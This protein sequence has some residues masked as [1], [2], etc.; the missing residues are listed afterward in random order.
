MS[1][2]A[3][4][5]RIGRCAGKE[6]SPKLQVLWQLLFIIFGIGFFVLG[7]VSGGLGQ[8]ILGT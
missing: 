6:L 4:S 7:L 5:I 3:I 1:K 2:S 8:I